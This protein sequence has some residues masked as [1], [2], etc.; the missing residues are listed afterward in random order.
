[1]FGPERRS[2]PRIQ[3]YNPVRLRKAGAPKVVE[4]LTKNVS[5]G[6]LRC[7]SQTIFPV[8]TDLAVDLVLSTGEAPC[9][10]T[11]RAVWL[12]MVPYSD[13][14]DVGIAFTSISPETKRRLS[15]YLEFLSEKSAEI[16]ASSIS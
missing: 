1:M 6:G 3:T 13:Q 9:T 10:V 15:A 2:F 12:R 16:H 11:G 5:L 4:T 14:F 8:S 7:L